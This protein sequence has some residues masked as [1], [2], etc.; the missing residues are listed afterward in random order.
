VKY[1]VKYQSRNG[2]TH[3]VAEI[4]A[5]VLGVQ[6]EP[7][8]A[9]LNENVDILFVGGGLYKGRLDGKLNDFLENITSEKIGKIIP[10][11]T[12]GGQPAVIK[13]IT[14]Y[15]LKKG[16][17]I[18]ERQLFVPMGLRGHSWFG[19]KGGKLKD[20]QIQKIKEF[21]NNILEQK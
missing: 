1:S 13:Q 4:I 9:P 15:A 6:A 20:K 2:N 19:L 18:D 10:F 16:I 21:V 12:S 3:A 8:D 17:K 11:G 14:E 5:N 7:A